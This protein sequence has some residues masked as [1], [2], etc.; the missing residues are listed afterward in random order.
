MITTTD[1]QIRHRAALGL[2]YDRQD[3]GAIEIMFFSGIA[4]KSNSNH[5]F[6]E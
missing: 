1:E 3:S 4:T 6:A 5:V 2:A